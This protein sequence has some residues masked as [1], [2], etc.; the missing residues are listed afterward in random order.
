MKIHLSFTLKHNFEN[1]R[2]SIDNQNQTDNILEKMN[3]IYDIKSK[4]TIGSD[5]ISKVCSRY[6]WVHYV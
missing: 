6:E 1:I 2:R 4:S 3:M 5:K